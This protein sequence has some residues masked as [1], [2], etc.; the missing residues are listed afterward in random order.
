M[1]R[2]KNKILYTLIFALVSFSLSA[3]DGSYT[4]YSPYSVFGVGNIFKQGTIVNKTMGGVGLATRDNSYINYLNPASLTARDSLA[5]MLDFGLNQR[6]TL[7]K[8]GSKT[9]VNNIFNVNNFVI[10]FPIYKSSAMAVGITPFSSF[11]FNFNK[12]LTD[13]ELLA[14]DLYGVYNYK[15]VGGF[16]KLFLSAAATFWDRFSVGVEGIYY[17][18]SF[19]KNT[20]LD[21]SSETVKNIRTEQKFNLRANSVKI[22]LQYKEKIKGLDFIWAATYRVSARIRGNYEYKKYSIISNKVDDIETIKPENVKPYKARI[23]DETGLG[24]SISKA[25][26]W[27]VEL[28]Y[29][30]SGWKYS[31][32]NNLPTF[33]NTV[34]KFS[35]TNSHSVR[36]G[37]QITPNINDIRYYFRRCTYR[38]GVYYNRDYFMLDN[39]GVNTFGMTLGMTLPILNLRNGITIGLDLGQRGNVLNN[40]IV[41][42]YLNFNVALNL[43]DIWFRKQRYN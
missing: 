27:S 19:E 21:F 37:F 15:G 25:K 38:G 1:L 10:S 13:N 4:S 43:A 32:V 30:M 3:E 35:I 41:E 7:Y 23:A 12:S 16:Y 34:S 28:N 40:N 39:K 20:S 14:N 42:R 31:H 18:G 6:N 17:F 26:H 36:A 24:F 2:N 22:G 8:Q 33:A 29:L 5:F 11:G 9:A